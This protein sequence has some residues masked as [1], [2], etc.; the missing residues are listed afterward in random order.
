MNRLIRQSLPVLL[1]LLFAGTALGESAE[2]ARLYAVVFEVTINS[3]GKVNKLR[4]SKVTDPSSGSDNA[5]DLSVPAEYVAA[6]RAFLSKRT[7]SSKDKQFF[8]YTFYD[9]MQPS[10]ADIDPQAE[11]R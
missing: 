10:K 7:Y 8:T 11:K 5:I 9:P 4:V 2:P 6:A 3:S 1:A